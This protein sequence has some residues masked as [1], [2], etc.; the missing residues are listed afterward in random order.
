MN[1]IRKLNI[2]MTYPVSWTP[3]MVFRDY[4]QNFFDAVGSEQF[5]EQFLY[6]YDEQ[7]GILKMEAAAAFDKEW[8]YFVGAST[9][10]NGDRS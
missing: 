8:L 5:G 10:R 4:I 7:A 3:R 9:K 2:L 1:N 6:D